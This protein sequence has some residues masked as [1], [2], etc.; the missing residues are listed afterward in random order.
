MKSV[1]LIFSALLLASVHALFGQLDTIHWLPPMHARD[2]WGPQFLYLS[3]PETDTFK[4][5]IRDGA[6]N[7]VATATI[8]NTQPYRYDIGQTANTLTLVTQN[9]LHQ[10]VKGKGLV[11]SGP[12]KFFAYYRVYASS[13]FHAGDLTCKGR[14]ALGT[15][16]RI[17]H[18]V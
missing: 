11:I 7:L 17:G 4:V 3:T 5:E 1:R 16:F 14:A 9:Q 6:G 18:L 15:T 2:D 13:G 8:S 12:K 10:V